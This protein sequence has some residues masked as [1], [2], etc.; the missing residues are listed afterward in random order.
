MVEQLN[1]V[2]LVLVYR[3]LEESEEVVAQCEL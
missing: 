2:F 1:V 3:V